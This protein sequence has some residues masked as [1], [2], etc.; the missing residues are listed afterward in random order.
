MESVKRFIT[1]KL[2]LQVNESKSA[3]A[4][5]QE[6]KFLGFSPTFAVR[7]IWWRNALCFQQSYSEGLHYILGSCPKSVIEVE[8][9]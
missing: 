5:P 9:F 4:K 2:K 6:R 8:E 3:V 1:T 7:Q